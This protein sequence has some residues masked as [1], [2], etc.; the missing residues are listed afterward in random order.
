MC[1]AS[2]GPPGALLKAS[3]AVSRLSWTVW[4]PFVLFISQPVDPTKRVPELGTL[5]PVTTRRCQWIVRT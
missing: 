2:S 3:G 4:K 5:I 1:L